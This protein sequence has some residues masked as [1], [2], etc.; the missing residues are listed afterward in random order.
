MSQLAGGV[1]ITCA[2]E[3]RRFTIAPAGFDVDIYVYTASTVGRKYLSIYSK[4]M[5]MCNAYKQA[6]Y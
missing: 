5:H 4:Y 2:N 3:C 6:Y 1:V